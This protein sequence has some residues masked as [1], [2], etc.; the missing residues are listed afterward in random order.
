LFKTGGADWI[1]IP[2]TSTETLIAEAWYPKNANTTIAM[3]ST[4]LANPSY[5]LAYMC[6]YTGTQWK[7]GCRDSVC[8]QSYWQLQGIQQTT[9]TAAVNMFQEIGAD[10]PPPPP[11]PLLP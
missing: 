9:G 10:V 3:T 5:V 6:T 7:C 2:Y 4:E 11:L 1:P 8:A